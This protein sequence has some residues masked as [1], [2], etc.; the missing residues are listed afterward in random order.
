MTL[1]LMDISLS[2]EDLTKNNNNKKKKSQEK[3]YFL[4][5]THWSCIKQTLINIRSTKISLAV[6]KAMET[7]SLHFPYT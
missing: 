5:N 7:F 2:V 3:N 1:T 6:A 4:D